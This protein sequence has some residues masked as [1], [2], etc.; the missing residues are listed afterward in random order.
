MKTIAFI[1]LALSACS[2]DDATDATDD[3]ANDGQDAD[4][5]DDTTT[6]DTTTDD[7][8]DDTTNNGAGEPPELA[9][10][11]AAHNAVRA[12]VNTD[13]PLP[14]LVWNEELEATARAWAD[15]CTDNEAPAGL[16]DHNDGRSDG[17]PYYVGENIY[18]SS[19]GATGADAVDSW[20]SEEVDYNP[21]NGSCSGVCGHYTQIVWRT[22]LELGCALSNCAGLTYGSSI[23]CNYGPG[24][25]SGGPA[26]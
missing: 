11:T 16:I 4:N 17:H 22:S 2:S 8:T 25:N 12:A 13:T 19:G 1:L 23:V 24:G 18:G 7:T 9:G 15:S 10:I 3:T 5:A 26:Y 14:P 6:D 21:A 20:A